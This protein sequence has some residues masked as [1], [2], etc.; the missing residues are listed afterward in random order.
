MAGVVCA[1]LHTAWTVGRRGAPSGAG[2]GVEERGSY[3]RVCRAADES[4]CAIR[5]R[6]TLPRDACSRI[7]LVRAIETAVGVAYAVVARIRIDRTASEEGCQQC[8]HD[9]QQEPLHFSLPRLCASTVGRRREVKRSNHCAPR[10]LAPTLPRGCVPM[11]ELSIAA[12]WGG[13]A[14]P[15]P[16][17]CV[18]RVR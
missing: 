1:T 7:R 11:R 2:T 14:Q 5:T 18:M 6:S 13:L 8:P 16:P 15:L 9:A 12:V 3:A 17:R 10:R 4:V